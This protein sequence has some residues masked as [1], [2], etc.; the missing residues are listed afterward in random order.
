MGSRLY[1]GKALVY[2]ESDPVRGIYESRHIDSGK[3]VILVDDKSQAATKLR[4]HLIAHTRYKDWGLENIRELTAGA[5][6]EFARRLAILREV[7][8]VIQ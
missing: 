1:L 8:P 3:M 6:V 5:D 7:F 4:L 2:V